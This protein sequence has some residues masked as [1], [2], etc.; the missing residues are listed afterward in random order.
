MDIQYSFMVKER[1]HKEGNK[2]ELTRIKLENGGHVVE[3]IF[4]TNDGCKLRT[5]WTNGFSAKQCRNLK[6]NLEQIHGENIVRRSFHI[7]P[8]TTYAPRYF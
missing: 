3:T 5:V 4:E 6:D 1:K 7:A 2:M 8:G